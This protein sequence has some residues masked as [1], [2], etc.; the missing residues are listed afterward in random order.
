MSTELV[1]RA[2]FL[3]LFIV[4]LVIRGLFGWKVRQAGHSSWS[5]DKDAV[6]R[7]GKWSII[8]RPIAF[9]CML[10]LVVLYATNP[11]ESSW[12]TVSLPG[13]LR[14]FGVGLGII[15]LPLLVWVHHTLREYWSTALQLRKSHLLITEGP[16][17]WVRHPMYTALML[18]FIGLSL[19]S[20]VWPFMLLVVLS[21]LF[22]YRVVGREEAMMIEQFGDQYRTYMERTGRFLPRLFLKS[23]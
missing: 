14:W 11:E 7:E 15:S 8:L 2:I 1:F 21:M 12:L 16:Y 13:W 3:V 10:A 18:C 4:L 23:G 17:G 20:A 22:F 19:V 6:E 5:V 9:L